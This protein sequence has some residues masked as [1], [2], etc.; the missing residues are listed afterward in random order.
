MTVSYFTQSTNVSISN[1]IAEFFKIDFCPL[2]PL[3]Q[4]SVLFAP[5]TCTLSYP[6]MEDEAKLFDY[7]NPSN[8][9]TLS[10]EEEKEKITN[11]KIE[12]QSGW[13]LLTIGKSY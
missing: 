11:L 9:I 7:E 12:D 2:S 4:N 3:S 6:H 5:S 1:F 10:S 8:S 13:K